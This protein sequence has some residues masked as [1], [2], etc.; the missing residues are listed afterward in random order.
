MVVQKT[1]QQSIPKQVQPIAGQVGQKVNQS[2]Q[3]KGPVQKQSVGSVP[4]QKTSIFKKWWFWLIIAIILA[5]GIYLL[6][7]L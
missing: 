1:P 5:V 2:S 6:F 3:N 4:L 7:F